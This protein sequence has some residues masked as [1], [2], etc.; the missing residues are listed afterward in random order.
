MRRPAIG[1]VFGLG[2]IFVILCA[3][4]A[5]IAFNV[6]F[7][8]IVDFMQ[9]EKTTLTGRAQKVWLITYEAFLDH[10]LLGTGYGSL[11]LTGGAP[12]VEVYT[13]LHPNPFLLELTQAHNG[14]LDILAT[15]GLVGA[16]AL[17]VF[18]GSAL[19]LNFV[20]LATADK[21]QY[22]PLAAEL[23]SFIFIASLV[24]NSAQ[25]AF[26]RGNSVWMFLVL[27]FLML[28]ST[29]RS[30]GSLSTSS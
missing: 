13:N 5:L 3:T 6:S 9:G 20:S 23:S 4:F 1:L 16:A 24:Y 21:W 8:D 19:W 15:L 29:D 26:L 17:G 25:S 14:Y 30:E 27:F 10:K 2:T 7:V 12:P 22:G 11:W 18:L 28:C